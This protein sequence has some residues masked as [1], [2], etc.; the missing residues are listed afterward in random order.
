V[1]KTGA[2][3]GL[4]G[5]VALVGATVVATSRRDALTVGPARNV[6]PPAERVRV[7]VLNAGGVSGRARAATLELRNF[8]F[9][10]VHYGNADR[11][12]RDSSA[13]VDRV[14]RPDL[15]TAV[16]DAL[17]I[18]RVS[19]EADPNLFVDVTV[20]LGKDWT[21]SALVMIAEDSV[22]VREPWDPR[23]WIGR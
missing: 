9:D 17:G 20:F 3:V 7:E 23:G 1:S 2:V 19:S 21:G 18:R 15:A 14:G 22:P 11:F 13:V 5:I 10:V 16:A 4:A 8:G 12:D 6:P